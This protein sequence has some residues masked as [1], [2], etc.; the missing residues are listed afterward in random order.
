M[1]EGTGNEPLTSQE[2]G[3]F[4]DMEMLFSSPGW[5]H[6]VKGWQNEQEYL[7]ESGFYSAKSFDE[8]RDARIRHELLSELLELPQAMQKQRED[9]IQE[10]Q[11]GEANPV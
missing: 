9:L 5:A 4:Q 8:L 11:N 7:R 3:F 2:K 10:R 6:L 1:T